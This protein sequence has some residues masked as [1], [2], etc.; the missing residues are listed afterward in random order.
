MITKYYGVDCLDC[1][2]FIVLSSYQAQKDSDSVDVDLGHDAIGCPHCG[3][4]CV[5]VNSEV[6][7]AFSPDGTQKGNAIQGT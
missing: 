2:K 7:H 4:G 6:R 5:R 3:A 1:G